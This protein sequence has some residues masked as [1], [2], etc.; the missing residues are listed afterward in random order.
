MNLWIEDVSA[1]LG[2][3]LTYSVSL[4]F[5]INKLTFKKQ[6][7]IYDAIT[8]LCNVEMQILKKHNICSGS[9]KNWEIG[10]RS[11]RI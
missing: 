6:L 7:S 9:W 1:T 5:K 3:T 11:M 8:K 10:K 4:T 2:F